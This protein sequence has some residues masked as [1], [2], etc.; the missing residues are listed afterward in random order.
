MNTSVPDNYID[1]APELFQNAEKA[2]NFCDFAKSKELFQVAGIL[3]FKCITILNTKKLLHYHP[4]LIT[5]TFFQV[6]KL[7]SSSIYHRVASEYVSALNEEQQEKSGT[8][9]SFCT[10]KI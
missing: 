3:N 8:L 10:L 4:L 5:N 6:L 9:L 1:E 7:S 2:L